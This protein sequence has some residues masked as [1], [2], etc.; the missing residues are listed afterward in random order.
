MTP[1][2]QWWATEGIRFLAPQNKIP[3]LEQRCRAAYEAGM[4]DQR[5]DFDLPQGSP[6]PE[7]EIINEEERE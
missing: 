4:A 1:F 7:S 5:Q 6:L 2:D 3:S